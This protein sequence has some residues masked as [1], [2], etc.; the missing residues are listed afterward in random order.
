[1]RPVVFAIL[2]YFSLWTYYAVMLL[3]MISDNPFHFPN[4]AMMIMTGAVLLSS[5]SPTA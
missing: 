4:Y 3:A 1:M 2:L 5:S